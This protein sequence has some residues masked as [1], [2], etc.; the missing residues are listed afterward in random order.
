M[1]KILQRHG[2]TVLEAA[3]ADEALRHAREHGGPIHLVIT[4]VM[5]HQSTGKKVA[6]QVIALRPQTKVIYVSGL[7]HG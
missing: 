4:D 6:E 2:Y 7:I 5:L 1:R 3:N